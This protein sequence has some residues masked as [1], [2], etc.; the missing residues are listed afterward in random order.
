MASLSDR[1]EME[2]WH[3]DGLAWLLETVDVDGVN[4]EFGDYAGNDAMAD[5]RRL[6]PGLIDEARNLRDD[7]WLMTELGEWDFIAE[8][9]AAEKVTGLP[10]GCA[11]QFTY[12]K[13]YWPT[14]RSRLS[15][16]AID[17]LPTTTNTIRPHAGSQ[18]NR[19]RY[20]YMAPHY[21]ELAGL[22]RRTGLDGATIFGEVSDYSPPNE[23]NY[24]AFARFTKEADLDWESF[25][26]E[27][28]EPRLGGAE[29]ASRFTSLL[30][31]FD[32]DELDA[33]AME[34][35][36]DEVR[37][38]AASL[39]DPERRRWAWLEERLSRRIHS[40]LCR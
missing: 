8:P 20:A 31:R 35:A 26:S 15:R 19:Q 29:A 32:A 37:T 5:M 17:R 27:E 14:V 1:P 24:L 9:D 33:V 7:L 2:P 39:P 22:A 4:I 36:R 34:A 23:L 21:A 11:Y 12:N 30:E 13:S 28:V 38:T 3:L 40:R 18:W 25:V 10:D 16:G 6:L